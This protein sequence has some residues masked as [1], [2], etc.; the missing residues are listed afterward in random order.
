MEVNRKASWLNPISLWNLDFS[1]VQLVYIMNLLSLNY[2]Y[3]STFVYFYH[4]SIWSNTT[5]A[6]NIWTLCFV[7]YIL[8]KGVLQS[9]IDWPNRHLIDHGRFSECST[10]SQPSR[11]ANQPTVRWA[12][13]FF[14]FFFFYKKKICRFEFFSNQHRPSSSSSSTDSLRSNWLDFSVYHAHSQSQLFETYDAYIMD[15]VIWS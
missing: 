15:F 6:C 12:I 1:H 7:S 10:Q 13:L 2:F 8:T 3:L 14:S 11:S 9:V 4:R 5:L